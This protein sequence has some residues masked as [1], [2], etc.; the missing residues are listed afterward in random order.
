[1]SMVFPCMKC[2]KNA[3][4]IININLHEIANIFANIN[5]NVNEIANMYINININLIVSSMKEYIQG[6]MKNE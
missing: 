6:E 3:I 4:I 1:M 5:I 2:I